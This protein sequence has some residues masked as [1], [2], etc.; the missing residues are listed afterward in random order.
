MPR[1]KL[2]AIAIERLKGP[3]SGRVEYFD[4]TLPGFALRITDKGSRSWVVFYRNGGRLRRMTIGSYPALGLADARMAAREAMQAAA[5]G[6]DPA[7]ER[8]AKRTASP[9]LFEGGV[10][11]FIDKYAS[12]NRSA[13]ETERIFKVYVLPKWRARTLENITRRDVVEIVET[14]LEERGPYMANRVLAAIRKFFNWAM[15]RDMVPASPAA[16]VSAPGRET[17]RDR[18]LSNDEMKYLWEGFDQLGWP[19]RPI[20]KMLLVTAQRRSEVATM[21][22]QNINL[23]AAVWTIPREMT[24]ADRTHEVPLSPLAVQILE[25]APRFGSY[26]FTSGRSGDKPVSGYSAPKIRVDKL[27]GV[28]GWRLHDLRRTA[29][30]VMAR[31]NVPPHVLGKIL[32]HASDSTQGVTAIY[33]RYAYTDEKRHALEAWDNHLTNLI[34][35]QRDNVSTART[36]HVD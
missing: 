1:I 36:V 6:N 28:T 16:M 17:K 29:A 20:F 2:T 3:E 14:V 35:P 12:R 4:L 9:D 33:N 30:S 24:K 21:Q 31:L 25:E 22:W 34:E 7:M 8:A 19:F 27:T 23:E 13:K 26:V 32:N 15:E 18:V 10:Q 11:L 5:R